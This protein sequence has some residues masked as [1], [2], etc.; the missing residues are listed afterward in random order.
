MGRYGHFPGLAGWQSTL[1][2]RRQS[3]QTVPT[4]FLDDM[5]ASLERSAESY[6]P[7]S[8]EALVKALWWYEGDKPPVTDSA[9]DTLALKVLNTF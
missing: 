1:E 5:W 3:L 6:P 9:E 4:L 8:P 2:K 7:E